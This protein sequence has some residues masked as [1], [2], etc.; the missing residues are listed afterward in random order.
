MNKPEA[1]QQDAMPYIQI[2]PD[3]INE[4]Y[5]GS[6]A[7]GQ[8]EAS[9]SM[10]LMCYFPAANRDGDNSFYEHNYI[11]D[12]ATNNITDDAGFLLASNFEGFS[13][14]L[15]KLLDYIN[16]DLTGEM[17]PQ[18]TDSTQSMA[19]SVSN[20]IKDGSTLSAEVLITVE[21]GKFGINNRQQI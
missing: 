5:T 14:W 1:L 21:T 2:L 20:I 18:L 8:K 7:R 12:N 4:F 11:V 17:N 19:I 16:T 6:N 9:L 3:A 13:M 15:E 10:T